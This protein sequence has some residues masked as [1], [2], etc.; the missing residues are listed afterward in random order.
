MPRADEHELEEPT[1]ARS[2]PRP[3][4]E[5]PERQRERAEQRGAE[6]ARRPSLALSRARSH[7]LDYLISNVDPTALD[8]FASLALARPAAEGREGFGKHAFFKLSLQVQRPTW[9]SH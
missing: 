4:R 3:G 7:F 6:D 1:S 5:V 2:R 8:T 9:P